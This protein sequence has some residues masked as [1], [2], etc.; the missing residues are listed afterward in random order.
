[1]LGACGGEDD[2]EAPTTTVEAARATATATEAASTT[3][4][5]TESTQGAV[6]ADAG[7]FESEHYSY[8]LRVPP[9][10][11]ASRWQQAS[12]TWD[13]VR[14]IEMAGPFVDI[15]FFPERSVFLYGTTAPGDLETFFTTVATDSDATTSMLGTTEST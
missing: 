15:A 12:M 6:A 1:M 13:G 14:K 3:I 4:A 7:T 10:V 11:D 8:T 9:D 2:T 5:A